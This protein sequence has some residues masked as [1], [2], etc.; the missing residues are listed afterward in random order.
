M[1]ILVIGNDVRS[2]T[3]ANASQLVMAAP[4]AKELIYI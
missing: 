4:G 3:K 1:P 2:E